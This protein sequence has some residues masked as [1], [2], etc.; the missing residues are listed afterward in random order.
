MTYIPQQPSTPISAH[1][2]LT[3][4][5]GLILVDASSDARTVTLPAP[6]VGMMI[7]VIKVDSSLNAVTISPPSGTISGAESKSLALQWSSYTIE[8]DGTNYYVVE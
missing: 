7:R 1:T 5:N 4:N 3:E 8:S 6:K 2:T